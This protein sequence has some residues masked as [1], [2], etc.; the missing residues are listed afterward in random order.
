MVCWVTLFCFQ[1]KPKYDMY[2]YFK[3]VAVILMV[4]ARNPRDLFRLRIDP[5]PKGN[6]NVQL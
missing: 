4:A 3:T 2:P 1:N 6:Q 5:K